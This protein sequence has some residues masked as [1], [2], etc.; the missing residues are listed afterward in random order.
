MS[1]GVWRPRISQQTDVNLQVCLNKDVE[2]TEELTFTADA[3]TTRP[4]VRKIDAH[5]ERYEEADR[6]KNVFWVFHI[7]KQTEQFVIQTC[8]KFPEATRVEIW[9]FLTKINLI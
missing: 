9:S 2:E 4:R 3:Q 6:S 5:R 8:L 7:R 1:P